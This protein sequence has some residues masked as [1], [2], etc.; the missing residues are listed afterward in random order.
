[1][2]GDYKTSKEAFVSG[3][4][5]STVMHVNLISVVAWSSIALY[6]AIRSRLPPSK[7]IP[8]AA[9]WMILVVPLLLSMTLFANTPSTLSALLLGPASL[10]LLFPARNSRPPLPSNATDNSPTTS[11]PQAL[12]PLPA[13]STYRSHMLIMTILSILAVDFPVFPRSLVKC[14]TYGVSLMDIGV[15]SF[16]FSQGIVSAIPMIKDPAYLTAPILP[17]FLTLSRKL[18]PIIALGLLRVVL[19]KGTE[20][21][22]HVTEYGVHWNFF[23]TLAIM[24]A[25]Q[26]LLHPIMIH[27]PLS[28]LG[29]WVAVLHQMSLSTM[30]LKQFVLTAPRTGLLSANKEGV[31]SLLG[32]FAIH[33]LGLATGTLIIPPSPSYFR[34]LQDSL[35]EAS[36]K[37]SSGKKDNSQPQ[38]RKSLTAPRQNGKTAI[39]LF[40][41]T[42]VWWALL[43]LTRFL[44]LDVSRRMANLTY[45]LWVVAYNTTFI[46]GYLLMDSYFFPAAKGQATAKDDGKVQSRSK[47]S[48]SPSLLDAINKNGLALFLLANV[49]T[50]VIN[51]SIPTM[52]TSDTWAMV[53]LGG[54]AFGISVVAWRLQSYRIWRF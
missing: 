17:K 21:P 42:V 25:V 22:E 35:V 30:G 13:L 3:M 7:T 46:L 19:V 14:E 49:V 31:S 50:G 47:L 37:S 45:I 18:A 20:Y 36:D 34:R 32:Y 40:S 15:G 2:D 52:Y 41:Y 54:Y 43:G 8:F 26:V 1:M 44:G 4:T 5:G 38:D 10:L 24:P 29:I 27:I 16:V 53:I 48:T 51:L 6:S 11:N 12:T 39:E 9:E 23:I 33:L 28:L